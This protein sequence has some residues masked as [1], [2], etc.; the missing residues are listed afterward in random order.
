MVKE[1][2]S[3]KRD[4]EQVKSGNRST[5]CRNFY[6][7]ILMEGAVWGGGQEPLRPVRMFAD[8]C[9]ADLT[10]EGN[11]TIGVADPRRVT[12]RKKGIKKRKKN[13]EERRLEK[14]QAR[15]KLS[16]IENKEERKKEMKNKESRG[17]GDRKQKTDSKQER[18]QAGTG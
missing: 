5:E 1:D 14:K 12:F 18:R 9:R 7:I 17:E 4:G 13:K 2:T 8:D 3:R 11:S 15:D 10:S 16:R 6:S